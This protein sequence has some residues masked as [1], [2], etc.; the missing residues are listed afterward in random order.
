MICPLSVQATMFEPVTYSC[1]AFRCVITRATCA[2]MW[3]ADVVTSASEHNVAG[4]WAQ[5]VWTER[6]SRAIV[7]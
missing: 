1:S 2:F 7:R 5:A 6:S 3:A 4:S